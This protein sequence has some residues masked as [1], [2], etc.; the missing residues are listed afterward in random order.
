[1]APL[2]TIL[3][4]AIALIQNERPPYEEC[5][6]PSI[7]SSDSSSDEEGPRTL[8][9]GRSSNSTPP[10]LSTQSISCDTSSSP[11]II[12]HQVFSGELEPEMQQIY[13]SIGGIVDQL[14]I[15]AMIIRQPVPLDEVTK[16]A[17]IDVSYYSAHDLNH[18]RECFPT[19]NADLQNRLARAITQ[20]RRNLIYR[21]RHRIAIA[22]PAKSHSELKN[23]ISQT[24]GQQNSHD[25]NLNQEKTSDDQQGHSNEEAISKG[26]PST[27]A[28]TFV[29][30][31]LMTVPTL[32]D[33]V[34][35]VGTQSS[36][37]STLSAT[38]DVSI[39]P[40]PVD[41]EVSAGV[42]FE[43]PYCCYIVQMKNAKAW[44]FVRPTYLY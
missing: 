8:D 39:P 19:A 27:K 42:G 4:V 6:S 40:C 3:V 35:D 21:Q 14:Y 7:P 30:P 23:S 5:P 2:L 43:C 1:M 16:A 38:D 11:T 34:S 9:I 24:A 20:R 10:D 36:Y 41:L 22:L 32:D 26:L 18:V 29:Q 12:H 37:T 25:D 28:T 17:S 15:M 44:R 31:A 13:K 33:A